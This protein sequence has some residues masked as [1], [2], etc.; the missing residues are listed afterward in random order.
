MFSVGKKQ[1]RSC[2]S[3]QEEDL[4]ANKEKEGTTPPSPRRERKREKG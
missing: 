3:R 4:F 2:P 1:K